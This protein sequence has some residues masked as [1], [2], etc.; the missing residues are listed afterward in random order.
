MLIGQEA[1]DSGTVTLGTNLQIAVFDQ[2]SAQ[3][4]PEATRWF[5]QDLKRSLE[6]YDYTVVMAYAAAGV[7]SND[8]V[9]STPMTFV[10]TTSTASLGRCSETGALTLMPSRAARRRASRTESGSGDHPAYRPSSTTGEAMSLSTMRSD[11]SPERTS[12][13][14]ETCTTVSA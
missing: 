8:E 9:I 12:P 5:A 14:G 6:R 4:D 7:G 10:A 1:P 11:G 13:D 3:L 2:T